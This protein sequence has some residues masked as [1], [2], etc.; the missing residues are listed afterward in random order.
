MTNGEPVC[1][2]CSWT[3]AYHLSSRRKYKCKACHH[4]F[5]LTSGTIFASRKLA[6]VDLLGTIA[7]FV[8]AAKG[9]SALQLSRYINVSYKT[10]LVLAHKLREKLSTKSR[11]VMLDSTVEVDGAHFGG[12]V[13]T[14]NGRLD[15]LVGGCEHTGCADH[16][17]V[18]AL[19]QRV[20]R[21]P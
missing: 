19:R 2:R 6:F 18:V 15:R 5:N 11:E 20:G 3:E 16:R 7:L 4:Q 10:A 9:M 1:P 17:S 8:N 13:R 14:A 12:H 21:R